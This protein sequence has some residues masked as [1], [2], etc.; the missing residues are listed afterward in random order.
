MCISFPPDQK[1]Y[2]VVDKAGVAGRPPVALMLSSC[3]Q[4]R[5]FF[6]PLFCSPTISFLPLPVFF[7]LFALT[8]LITSVTFFFFLF[9]SFC[10]LF[11]IPEV[12]PPDKTHFLSSTSSRQVPQFHTV[13]FTA[14]SNRLWCKQ[15]FY[16]ETTN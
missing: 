9:S 5:F 10:C 4:M 14:I 11:V 15:R 1:E 16:I 7:A 6:L 8:E 12:R 2:V 13:V 3:E